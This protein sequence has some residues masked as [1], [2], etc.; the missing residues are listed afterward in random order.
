MLHRKRFARVVREVYN[1]LFFG[2]VGVSLRTRLSTN[3]K[4]SLCGYPRA[5]ICTNFKLRHYQELKEFVF[6]SAISVDNRIFLI[7]QF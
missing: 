6:P 7:K 3:I 5:R 4:K 2:N 1:R